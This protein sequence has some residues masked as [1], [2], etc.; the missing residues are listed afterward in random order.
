MSSNEPGAVQNSY[1]QRQAEFQQL[2]QA[3]QAGNLSTAQQDYAQLTQSTASTPSTNSPWSSQVFS[4]L[5]QSLKV[6]V[7]S[8]TS[9]APSASSSSPG[10][11]AQ[12]FSTL[13]QA[14]QAGSLSAAQQAYAQM[15]QSALDMQ[16]NSNHHHR[17][18]SETA[19]TEMNN[20]INSSA[21]GS[22]ASSSTIGSNFLSTALSLFSAVA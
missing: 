16:Q 3:L 7:A 5:A 4:N 21:G 10:S 13:G 18:V 20:S 22:T 1:Q 6:Q 17:T 11:P 15:Q 14:L 19:E 12:E 2:G 9:G 8:G